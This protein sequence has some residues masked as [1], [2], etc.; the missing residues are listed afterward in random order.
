MGLNGN[1]QSKLFI[2]GDSRISYSTL[3]F[4]KYLNNFLLGNQILEKRVIIII[5][6]EE[7]KEGNNLNQ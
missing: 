5:K 1:R 2:M 6:F 4:R 3:K 7:E